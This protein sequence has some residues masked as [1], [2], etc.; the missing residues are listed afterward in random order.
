M[1]MAFFMV[2][3]MTLINIPFMMDLLDL[4][5]YVSC[6]SPCQLVSICIVQSIYFVC[7]LEL[8]QRGKNIRLAMEGGQGH[9]LAVCQ[10][11]THA[12]LV[13]AGALAGGRGRHNCKQTVFAFAW[14][15]VTDASQ[16]WRVTKAHMAHAG[17]DGHIRCAFRH[18]CG[19]N[20]RGI[21]DINP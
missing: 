19:I 20:G 7:S 21:C 18:N 10:R 5:S 12:L 15:L 9:V 17:L 14:F 11:R 16:K 3:G 1:F 2:I 8:S 4:K 13:T 6:S